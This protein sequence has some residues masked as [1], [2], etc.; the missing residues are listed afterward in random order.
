[1]FFDFFVGVG[2]FK[3]DVI[4]SKFGE[5]KVDGVKWVGKKNRFSRS[6]KRL[7]DFFK[8]SLSF[9]ISVIVID[10]FEVLDFFVLYNYY[11]VVFYFYVF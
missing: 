5:G 10:I 6:S 8:L 11:V 9:I 2:I 4:D 7:D 1:M 3:N